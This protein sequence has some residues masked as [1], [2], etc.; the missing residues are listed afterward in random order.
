MHYTIIS[1]V[2]IQITMQ[3]FDIDILDKFIIAFIGEVL[4]EKFGRQ[5][6]ERITGYPSNSS[7]MSAI[8]HLLCMVCI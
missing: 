7:N 4:G 3:I 6:F 1:I 8:K 5:N 2:V